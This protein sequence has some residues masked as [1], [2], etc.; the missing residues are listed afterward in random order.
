MHLT[1][2]KVL[3]KAVGDTEASCSQRRWCLGSWWGE[4]PFVWTPARGILKLDTSFSS[5][6]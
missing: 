4:I 1:N 3:H 5:R 6:N 2:C